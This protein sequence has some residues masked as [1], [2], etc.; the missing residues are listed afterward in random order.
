MVNEKHYVSLSE[1][2]SAY[3][4]HRLKSLHMTQSEFAE[5]MGVEDRTVRRWISGDIHKLET[6]E[7]IAAAFH[8]EA[9]N[10][11]TFEGGDDVFLFFEGPSRGCANKCCRLLLE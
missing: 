8:D 7:D 2:A 11:V 1:N 9:I 5:Y 6:V 4:R 3:L 10:V